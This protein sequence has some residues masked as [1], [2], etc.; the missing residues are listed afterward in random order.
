VRIQFAALPGLCHD[1]ILFGAT[2]GHASKIRLRRVSIVTI[3]KKKQ[4]EWKRNK[5]KSET[6]RC[7]NYANRADP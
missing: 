2:A 7:R 4:K 5:T 6:G 3:N 1:V